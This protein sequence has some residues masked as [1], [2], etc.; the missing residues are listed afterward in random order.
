MLKRRYLYFKYSSYTFQKL[1]NK[2]FRSNSIE[3]SNS[4]RS[5]KENKNNKKSLRKLSK[6]RNKT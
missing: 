3:T 5:G 1:W 6:S 4:Y 2:M